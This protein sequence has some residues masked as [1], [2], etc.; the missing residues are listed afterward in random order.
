MR[1]GGRGGE[2]EREGEGGEGGREEC[3]SIVLSVCVCVVCVLT[4]RRLLEVTFDCSDG[5]IS[6]FFAAHSQPLNLAA[7]PLKSR[8]TLVVV[9]LT[10]HVFLLFLLHNKVVIVQLLFPFLLLVLTERG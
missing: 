7:E 1:E 8:L 9:I 3:A 10:D 4:R 5:S 6:L 2:R